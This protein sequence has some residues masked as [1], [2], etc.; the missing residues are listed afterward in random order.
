[1]KIT[2]L[3]FLIFAV[4]S[5]AAETRPNI[6]L[7]MADDQGWGETGYYGLPHPNRSSTTSSPTRMKPPTYL[8]ST[9]TSSKP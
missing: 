7:M 8:R 1:M 5:L 4:S 9:R 6:V 2:S 3:V